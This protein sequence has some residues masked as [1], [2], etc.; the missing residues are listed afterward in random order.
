MPA[1]SSKVKFSG[2]ICTHSPQPMHSA[3]S[4]DIFKH[5]HLRIDGARPR[6]PGHILTWGSLFVKPHAHV[7]MELGY[8]GA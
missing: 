3:R 5:P 6:R 2:L 4:K 1:P 7:C 8:N